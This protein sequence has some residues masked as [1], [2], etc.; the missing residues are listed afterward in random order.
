MESVSLKYNRLK[1]L[2]IDKRHCQNQMNQLHYQ[3]EALQNEYDQINQQ[4]YNTIQ[5]KS[6]ILIECI[7]LR[8][9]IKT[10]YTQIVQQLN[11][12]YYLFNI[13][14]IIINHSKKEVK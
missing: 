8:N 2:L 11:Q 1:D 13:L 5:N 9:E 3:L 12:L 7:Q 4:L 14:N 6:I 10:K